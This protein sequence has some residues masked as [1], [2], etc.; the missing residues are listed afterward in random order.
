MATILEFPASLARTSGSA[1]TMAGVAAQVVIFP[2]VRYERVDIADA[3]PRKR[4]AAR[5]DHLELED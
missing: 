5:R 1:H 3:K 4:P 2:G